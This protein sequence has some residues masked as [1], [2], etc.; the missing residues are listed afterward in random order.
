ML[1]EEINGR[2]QG[3][4]VLW[5]GFLLMSHVTWGF[6]LLFVSRWVQMTE[7]PLPGTQAVMGRVNSKSNGPHASW[8]NL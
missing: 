6:G 7:Q 2:S 1:Q 3:L 8:E 4:T 5:L